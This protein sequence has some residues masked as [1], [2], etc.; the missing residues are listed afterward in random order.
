MPTRPIRGIIRTGETKGTV[1]F[2]LAP[3][4]IVTQTDGEI[5]MKN[6][7]KTAPYTDDGMGRQNLVDEPHCLMIHVALKPGQR[8]PQH[9]ANSNVHIVVLEGAIVLNMDG[10]DVGATRGD[11]VPV[12]HKTAMNIRNNSDANAT[13]IVI[14]TPNP[15]Q[16]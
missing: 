6:L 15:S 10:Q 14:K 4:A 5:K 7:L 13:F 2:V 16:M 11:F 12:A 1:P 3:A 8:V 9:N